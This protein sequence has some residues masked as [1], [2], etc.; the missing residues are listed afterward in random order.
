MSRS[1]QGL[2]IFFLL[3]AVLVIVVF[4]V[5]FGLFGPSPELEMLSERE[6]TDYEGEPL[7]SVLDFRENS[8]RGPQYVDMGFYR[9]KI[10]GLVDSPRNFTYDAVL[11]TFPRYGKVTTLYC[12]EGWD[13]TIFW[14]GVLVSDLL[15]SSNIRPEADTVIFY[16]HDGYST[17]L[18]LDYILDRDILLAYRMNNVTIPAERGHPFVLVAEEKWGYKW[19]KWVTT[20]EVSDDPAYRGYWE[21]RGYS[22]TADISEDFFT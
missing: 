10:R 15:D 14:E 19:I 6:I 20:I 8:I 9:L 16:A 21:Q 22:Q 7:S 1:K 18:P 4:F 11:T 12:V 17:S 5:D 3:I 2:I 13:V